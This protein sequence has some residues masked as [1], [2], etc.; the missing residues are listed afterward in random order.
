MVGFILFH[1]IFMGFLFVTV[2]SW[3]MKRLACVQRSP[4]PQDKSGEETSV[5]RRRQSCSRFP[6]MLGTASDWL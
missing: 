1:G 5:N 4:L 2:F 3:A 6:G